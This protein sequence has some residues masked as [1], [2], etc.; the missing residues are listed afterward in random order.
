MDDVR[1]DDLELDVAVARLAAAFRAAL[2]EP[3]RAS[4]AAGLGTLRARFDEPLPMRGLSPVEVLR[5]LEEK[6]HDGLAG[7]TG[8]RYFGFVTGGVLP[9]AAIVEAWTAAVDQN[10]GM[11]S[12]GPAA[13]ELEQRTLAWLA[14]LLEYP[15]GS[16][17]F[18]SGA[19]MANTIGLAL[20]RQSFGRRHGVDVREDGVRALPEFR[21]YGSD[22]LHLSDFKALRTLG[23]G[24]GCVRAIP[25]DDEYAMRVD[26]LVDAIAAD[27]ARGVEP[28]IV[29]AQIGSVNTGA[30]DPVEEIA[31][32]CEQE[33]IWLH[34]DAAFGAFF[35]LCERTRPLA[36]GLERADSVAVDAHKWLNVP[37]GV[38][39][40]LTR[41]S[42]LHH[43][44]FSGTASYLTADA[45]ANLHE[46]GIEAS[47]SWRGACV[48][49]A[50]KELGREGLEDLITRCC[51]LTR[52]LADRI[53]RSP[54]LELTAPAPTCVCCFRFRPDGWDEGGRLDDL[55]RA[56][57]AEVARRGN[58]F[59]TGATLANGFSL[60]AAIVSWRTGREDIEA[61]IDEVTKIGT[62]IAGAPE[63]TAVSAPKGS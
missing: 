35:R 15:H 13:V 31:A 57:Q 20:A 46:L 49:A 56:I 9:A 30:S 37:N 54:V 59:F 28:A 11:W 50:L 27:R 43:E 60:R 19:T 18:A 36:A 21:V 24:A 39:F 44:T 51:D 38:G 47:R 40:A 2:D 5:E 52:Q 16:G 4:A 26:L 1:D 58:V 6:A 42:E 29:I 22:E 53:A 23:L 33:G 45:G 41:H 8:S 12:L 62:E 17:Y 25:I 3:A 61:L 32:L 34:V 63:P 55:N 48:W 10:V 7:G 14:E